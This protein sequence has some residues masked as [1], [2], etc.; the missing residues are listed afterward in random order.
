MPIFSWIFLGLIAGYI[1]SRVVNERGDAVF[2]DVG[3]VIS[4][5]I[6]GGFLFTWMGAAGV[7]EFH[8]E[9]MF[10]EVAAVFTVLVACQV[11]FVRRPSGPDRESTIKRRPER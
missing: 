11:M 4:G 6:Y 7:S 9:E 10:V 5:A 1:A 8:L 2:I 3:L